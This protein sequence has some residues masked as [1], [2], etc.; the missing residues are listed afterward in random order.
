MEAGGGGGAEGG[1]GLC[2]KRLAARS[3][4]VYTTHEGMYI[5]TLNIH[6]CM[7]MAV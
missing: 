5:T 1:M 7:A 6:D 3:F 4:S 2:D